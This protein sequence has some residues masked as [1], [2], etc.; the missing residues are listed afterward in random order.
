VHAREISLHDLNVLHHGLGLNG[1]L[2]L[3]L[4]T[5]LSRFIQRY[6]SL[7]AKVTRLNVTRSAN[8]PV[9]DSEQEY[10]GPSHERD[11]D[12]YQP[13]NDDEQTERELTGDHEGQAEGVE[14]REDD[15]STYDAHAEYQGEHEQAYDE[16]EQ[17]ADAQ[18]YP[19]AHEDQASTREETDQV[20]ANHESESVL[21]A[22]PAYDGSATLT[23]PEY[24]EADE[25]LEGDEV[26]GDV[27][28]TSTV[29]VPTHAKENVSLGA[30]L[31][32]LTEVPGSATT[33]ESTQFGDSEGS[34][35][36]QCF[37]YL[38]SCTLVE[39]Q[40]RDAKLSTSGGASRDEQEELTEDAEAGAEADITSDKSAQ[41]SHPQNELAVVI[42]EEEQDTASHD[43]TDEYGTQEGEP[44]SPGLSLR[45][46]FPEPADP[47]HHTEEEDNAEGWELDDGD[48]VW[49]DTFDGDEFDVALAG[50]PDSVSTGSSTLSGNTASITSKRSFDEVEES[51]PAGAQSSIQNLKKTRTR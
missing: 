42:D 38:Y 45:G 14:E 28:V 5:V 48:A 9:E 39:R 7:Q 23:S 41:S 27:E 18:E 16:S 2:R 17:Y 43:G 8:R 29:T 13:V 24:Q 33:D 36:V 11:S 4:R 20:V 21:G 6:R 37:L 15:E 46:E 26:S 32:A 34:S 30:A 25:E 3:R 44:A 1:P 40:V 50:E 12:Y 35:L 19:Q 51:E 49:D 31:D 10:V 47:Y 22:D